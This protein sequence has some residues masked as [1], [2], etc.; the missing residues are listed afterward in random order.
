MNTYQV[1]SLNM[2]IDAKEIL[3]RLN[4][5]KEDRTKRTFTISESLYEEFQETCGDLSTSSVV[6]ELMR[7]F[8]ESA[9]DKNK[10]K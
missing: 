10:T 6:E 9:K 2:K 4:Q 7:Q 8:V 3:N 5:K 1:I